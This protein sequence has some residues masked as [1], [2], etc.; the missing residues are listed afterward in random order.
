MTSEEKE[1]LIAMH[2]EYHRVR[3]FNAWQ[4]IMNLESECR[5]VVLDAIHKKDAAVIER[6][7][8][9]YKKRLAK[10]IGQG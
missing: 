6:W 7:L 2:E 5:E 10:C 3:M 9:G 4:G 8:A 1:Q